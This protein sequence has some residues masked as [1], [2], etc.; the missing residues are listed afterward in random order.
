MIL[1]DSLL[2]KLHEL[3]LC[4][5][6]NTE[7]K[8][9]DMRSL[10]IITKLSGICGHS[11]SHVTLAW[12]SENSIKTMNNSDMKDQQLGFAYPARLSRLIV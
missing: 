12:L 8:E 4:D 2:D 3:I 6:M 5:I 1:L 10:N 9:N 11:F 7:R